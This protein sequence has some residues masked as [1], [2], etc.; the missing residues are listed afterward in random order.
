MIPTLILG[1]S[2]K[3]DRGEVSYNNSFNLSEIKRFYTIVNK[4]TSF[5]RRWQ[6]HKIEQR[7][8]TAISGGFKIQLILVDNWRSPSVD[9]ER[10]TFELT[11]NTLD[12]LHIPFGYV[13]SIQSLTESSKLLIMSDYLLNE[14]NDEYRFPINYFKEIKK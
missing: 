9:L 7:W 12:V 5:T 14:I 3:D 2:Y 1:E 8:F 4:D 10:I 13:S 6:G 11:C